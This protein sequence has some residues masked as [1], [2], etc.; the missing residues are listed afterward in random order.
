MQ[1]SVEPSTS[2][3]ASIRQKFSSMKT[4]VLKLKPTTS[5]D[6]DQINTFI[7][8]MIG[9]FRETFT[10]NINEIR[11]LI[12]HARPDPSD[13][14]YPSKL[15]LYQELLTSMV[16][17]IQQIQNSSEEIL[18]ELNALINQLWEDICQNN[19]QEVDRL[20]EGHTRRTELKI[21]RIFL[22]PLDQLMEKIS[23]I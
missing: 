17:V 13:P 18:T 4:L 8:T 10:R 23:R 11:D 22:E 3:T 19:G 2:I 7:D 14:N 20:L 6:S 16:P 15:Q 21:N 5:M 12:K 9:D 1:Q